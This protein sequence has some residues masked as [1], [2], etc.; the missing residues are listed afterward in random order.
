MLAVWQEVVTVQDRNA[1]LTICPLCGEIV[2]SK[3]I[4]EGKFVVGCW[5]FIMCPLSAA[6][7]EI[8]RDLNAEFI[9]KTEEAAWDN[10][11]KLAKCFG[12]E[13]MEE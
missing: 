1:K 4:A 12:W 2:N 13:K 3:E 10:C 11:E 9:F 7:A 6:P 5:R 8:W